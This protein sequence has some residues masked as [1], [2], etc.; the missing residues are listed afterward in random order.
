M[1]A[2]LTPGTT[3]LKGAAREPEVVALCR[4]LRDMGADIEGEGT[5]EIIVRG[6]EQ[7]AGTHVDLIGDRIESRYLFTCRHCDSRKCY[8]HWNRSNIFR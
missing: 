8:G 3:V 1:A 2:A 4:M 5:S 7:L 6:V